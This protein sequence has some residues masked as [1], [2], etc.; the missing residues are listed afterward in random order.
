MLRKVLIVLS[1]VAA[2]GLASSSAALARGGGHGGGHGGFHGGGFHGGGWHGGGWRGGGIGW[3][4]GLVG[5]GWGLG[6]GYPYAY[7]RYYAYEDYGGCYPAR[8]RIKT[9]H[10]WRIRW[11]DVCE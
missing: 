8:Q 5:L 1:A 4:P 11:V 9:R 2:L 6:Y 10:G 7:P 3:G